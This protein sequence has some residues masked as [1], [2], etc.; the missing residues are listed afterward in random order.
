MYCGGTCRGWPRATAA[1]HGQRGSASIGAGQRHQV[2]PAVGDDCLGHVRVV[3]QAD[4]A[5]DDAGFLADALGERHLIAGCGRD[6]CV[7]NAAAARGADIGGADVLQRLRDRDRLVDREAAVHPFAGREACP[8]HHRGR[9]GGAHR[10][11]DR[12]DE[13]HPVVERAAPVVGAL[14]GERREELVEQVAVGAVDLDEVEAGARGALGGGGPGADEALD[15]VLVE[16]L[17]HVPARCEGDGRRCHGLPGVFVGAERARRPCQGRLTEALRPAWPSW[18][19]KRV[20]PG[21]TRRAAASV[22]WAA[23]SLWSE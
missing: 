20:P 5:R 6:L 13:A 9:H 22:R 3:D 8:D 2:G 14:V 17:R 7:V 1:R 18:M 12:H 10:L 16:G 19:P 11:G 21:A 15:A 23:A 4:G